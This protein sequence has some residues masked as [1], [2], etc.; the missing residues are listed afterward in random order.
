MKPRTYYQ[1]LRQGRLPGQLIIQLTDRCNATCPQCGMNINERFPRHSLSPDDVRRMIDAA[2]DRGIAAISFTGG[3][4]LLPLGDLV[5]LINHAG[6]AGMSYIRTGTNGFAFRSPEAAT[7]SAG[8]VRSCSF[9]R[10]TWNPPGFGAGVASYVFFKANF[11][12]LVT[13]PVM[14]KP[15]AWRGDATI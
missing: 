3:E 12:L 2:A 13:G 10:V 8:R 14:I 4:P 15:S 6:A 5:A 7:S 9:T 11:M 1:L